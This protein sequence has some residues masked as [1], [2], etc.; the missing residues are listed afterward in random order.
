MLTQTQ[1]WQAKASGAPHLAIS[2]DRGQ[3]KVAILQQFA[4][5]WIIL[6][7]RNKLQ[8]VL[9]T[10]QRE[11]STAART[12]RATAASATWSSLGQG[13]TVASGSANLARIAKWSMCRL[14]CLAVALQV[15]CGI[16]QSNAVV[17]NSCK[18]SLKSQPWNACVPTEWD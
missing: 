3:G 5:S 6:L 12:F 16:G 14:R 9:D 13:A 11:E 10:S 2:L 15:G 8:V 17:L 4:V 18:H 7:S 1:A